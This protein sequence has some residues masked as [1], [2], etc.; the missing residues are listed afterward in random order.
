MLEDADRKM[1]RFAAD[2]RDLRQGEDLDVEMPADL[3]Q[4]R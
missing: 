1:T 4:F 3:D 2:G